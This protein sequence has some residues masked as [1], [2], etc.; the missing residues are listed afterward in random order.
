MELLFT[1]IFARFSLIQVLNEGF[2]QSVLVAPVSRSGIVLGKVSGG[3]TMALVQG[4][5]FLLAAPLARV[6]LPV[7]SFLVASGV[8]AN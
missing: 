2:L 1:A 4:L 6:P 7:T 8:L 3:A 5:L